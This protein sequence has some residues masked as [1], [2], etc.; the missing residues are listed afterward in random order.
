M[1]GIFLFEYLFGCNKKKLCTSFPTSVPF[2]RVS[3]IPFEFWLGRIWTCVMSCIWRWRTG[4]R[5]YPVSER[6]LSCSEALDTHSFQKFLLGLPFPFLLHLLFLL[7]FLILLL[8]LWFPLCPPVSLLFENLKIY[9][10]VFNFY[11]YMLGNF[12]TVE[13]G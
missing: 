9:Y 10:K 1:L 2:Y 7:L 13:Q 5:W 4:E 8:P 3:N 12:S 11:Q 6:W